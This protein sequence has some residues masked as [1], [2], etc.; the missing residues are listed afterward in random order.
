MRDIGQISVLDGNW[1]G[2]G[3]FFRWD[4]NT[5][6]MK[7]NSEYKSQAKKKIPIVNSAIS[8]FWSPTVTDFR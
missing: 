4:L 7:N 3:A 1:L 6:F 5:P 8:Q 2:G